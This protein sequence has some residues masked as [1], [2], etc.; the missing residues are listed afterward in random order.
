MHVGQSCIEDDT[1]TVHHTPSTSD[2]EMRTPIIL[3]TPSTALNEHYKPGRNANKED[4]VKEGAREEAP[5]MKVVVR[6]L[7]NKMLQPRKLMLRNL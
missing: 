7:K 6:W 4:A 3:Y 2:M 5:T 1:M